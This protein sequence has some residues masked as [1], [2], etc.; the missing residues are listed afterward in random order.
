M[1]GWAVQTLLGRRRALVDDVFQVLML[2]SDTGGQGP[3]HLHLSSAPRLPHD[4]GRPLL[5]A[6]QSLEPCSDTVYM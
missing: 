3:G 6:T 1:V 4:F 5:T 2:W